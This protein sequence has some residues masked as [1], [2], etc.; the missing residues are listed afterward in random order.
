MQEKGKLAMHALDKKAY[1][2]VLHNKREDFIEGG[3]SS[4]NWEYN[5]IKPIEG[6][7]L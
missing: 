5:S 4:S 2:I 1:C 6:C 7:M 3:I